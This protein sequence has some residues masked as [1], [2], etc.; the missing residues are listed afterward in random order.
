MDIETIWNGWEDAERFSGVFSAHDAKG[1]L[2]EKCQGF[3]SLGERLKNNS[4]T[5]FGIA[6]GTKL[7]TG[8]A[9]CRLIDGGKL[10]LFDRLWDVLPYDLGR[11]DKRVTVYHL[12][13]HT[14]GIGDYLDEEDP[15]AVA[16][17]QELVNKY[18]VYL[19]ESLDYYLPMIAPLP[20]KFEPGERF[21]Y[22]N[23]GYVL[24]GLVIEAVSGRRYQDFVTEEIIEKLSLRHTGFYRMDELPYNTAYGYVK[25]GSGSWRTNIFKLP[26]IGGSDGGLFTCAADLDVLWRAVFDGHVLSDAVLRSFAKPQV[27]IGGGKS[28]GLGVYRFNRNGKTAFYAVGGDFAVDFFTVY[29]PR[30]KLTVSAL[31]NTELNTK[32]LLR[33]LLAEF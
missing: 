15:N 1:V 2:F 26:V 17:E 31:G 29:F 14:S 18:P 19:W 20:P 5:A 3:R 28:C 12:L 25:T 13:M 7:F 11:I 33:A 9:V 24:L 10:S 27:S 32:P 21:G 22:S 4:E 16:H 6:S 8:L 23:A 30:E